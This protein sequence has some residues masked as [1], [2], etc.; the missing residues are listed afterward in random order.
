YGVLHGINKLKGSFTQKKIN[1]KIKNYFLLNDYVL[2]NLKKTSYPSDLRFET[3]YPIDFPDFPNPPD[4]NKNDR[5]FWIGIPGQVEYK[6]RDYEGLVN[7]VSKITCK[8]SI[9]FLLLGDDK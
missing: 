8:K 1:R 3:Y 6:R 5:E 7:A 9:R 2:D 4:I